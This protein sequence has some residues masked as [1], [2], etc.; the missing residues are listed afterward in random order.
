MKNE[1]RERGTAC[2]DVGL[3]MHMFMYTE[4]SPLSGKNG[5]RWVFG[6]FRICKGSFY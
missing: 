6:M 5:F 1:R 3:D 4:Y 2:D